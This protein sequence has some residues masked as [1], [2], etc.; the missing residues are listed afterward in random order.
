MDRLG[1]GHEEI[2]VDNPSVIT[3]TTSLLGGGGPLSSLAGYGFHAAAIAGFTDLVGW[4]DLGPDGPWMAYTDTI[5]PRFLTTAILAALD[6]RDRT[7]RGLPHRGSAARDRP[8]ATSP[9]NCSTTS[10]PAG[11][12]TRIGNRDLHLAPQGAYRC[13][14]EDEWCAHHRD[15]RRQPGRRFVEVAR[16]ARTGPPT[17]RYATAAGRLAGPRR[18]RR[19]HRGVDGRPDGR[20]RR[21]RC[22]PAPGIPAGKVQRT[23]DLRVDPQY[24]HR[25]FYRRLEHA[26]VGVIPYAGHQF[27]IRGYDNGPR[28]AAPMLGEH[29]FEVMSELLGMT[30]LEIAAVAEQDG[31]R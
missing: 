7:G 1:L 24:L 17:A 23:R 20:G 26:E 11:M 4:P 18:D 29:T 8:A 2:A 13:A 16:L 10:S 27:R 31:L 22:W 21:A 3:V 15:R 30:D 12:P 28:A 9:P 5:A 14:G 19:P 6:R 25:R